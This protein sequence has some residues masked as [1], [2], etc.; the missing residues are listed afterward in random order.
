[1]KQSIAILDLQELSGFGLDRF[2]VRWNAG[3]QQLQC[4]IISSSARDIVRAIRDAH[5][6]VLSL[7]LS[8]SLSLLVCQMW[9]DERGYR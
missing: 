2:N 3:D 4:E 6:Q 7:S 5:R 9:A 8:L 1:V